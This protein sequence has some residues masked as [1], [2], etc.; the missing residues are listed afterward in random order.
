MGVNIVGVI[1]WATSDPFVNGGYR[2]PCLEPVNSGDKKP[3]CNIWSEAFTILSNLNPNSVCCYSVW[4]WSN[5]ITGVFS[6]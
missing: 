6:I 4:I 2:A 3:Q 1:I 5:L